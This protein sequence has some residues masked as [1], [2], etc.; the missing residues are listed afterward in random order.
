MGIYAVFST[1][2]GY[3]LGALDGKDMVHAFKKQRDKDVYTILKVPKKDMNDM[4]FHN[5]YDNMA[6]VLETGH[7]LFPD[8]LEVIDQGIEQTTTSIEIYLQQLTLSTV[9]YLN[10][11]NVDEERIIHEYIQLMGDWLMDT[12]NFTQSEEEFFER[13]RHF[14]MDLFVKEN[15]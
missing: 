7:I 13:E 3:F 1:S 5:I 9:P 11:K 14:N 15:I 6:I 10:F 12:N 4:V 8:E 2:E